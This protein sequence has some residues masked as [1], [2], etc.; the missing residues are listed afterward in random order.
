MLDLE[1]LL[2]LDELLR[3]QRRPTAQSLADALEC[4]E[5]TVR[6][7]IAYMRDRFDAPIENN[8]Q[9]GWHCTEPNCRL[10]SVSLTKGEL[11]ARLS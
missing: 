8:R 3:S 2:Q 10:S 5:K 9:Q 7:Y 6:T 4:N 1:R 11:F